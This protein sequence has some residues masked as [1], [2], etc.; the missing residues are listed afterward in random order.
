MIAKQR[1]TVMTMGNLQRC[2]HVMQVDVVVI[3]SNKTH[4]A[5]ELYLKKEWLP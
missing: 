3:R 2:N 5:V 1:L 4:I